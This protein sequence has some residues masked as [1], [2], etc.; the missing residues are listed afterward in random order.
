MGILVIKER[1]PSP[2][3]VTVDRAWIER[4]HD[5]RGSG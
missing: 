4:T 3:Y 2:E 5:D 1:E